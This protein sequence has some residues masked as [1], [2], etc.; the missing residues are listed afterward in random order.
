MTVQGEDELEV[1][2]AL[3]VLR[4]KTELQLLTVRGFNVKDGKAIRGNLVLPV[5]QAIGQSRGE[6]QAEQ[7]NYYINHVI[8]GLLCDSS[9]ASGTILAPRN[10]EKALKAAKKLKKCATNGTT[11]RL[12]D[13]IAA[14]AEDE[15]FTSSS[16]AEEVN[17][18]RAQVGP[19]LSNFRNAGL[20][21]VLR[22]NKREN[23]KWERVYVRTGADVH[24]PGSNA[25]KVDS[26]ENSALAGLA[27]GPFEAKDMANRLTISVRHAQL[28][29]R[30][31]IAAGT[32]KKLPRKH[33]TEI[34]QYIV[35]EK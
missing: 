17:L 25:A 6:I 24:T 21:T 2:N 4:T 27:K 5:P 1:L 11:K 32:V 8:P 13:A 26:A 28:R 3:E 16:L 12:K 19:Y 29:L 31:M 18:E 23:G 20:I 7:A 34:Q 22:D 30:K 35:V 9:V 14:K 10:A 15:E 33:A